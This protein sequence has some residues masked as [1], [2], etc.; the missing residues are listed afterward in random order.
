MR[1][2]PLTSSSATSFGR[3][4]IYRCGGRPIVGSPPTTVGKTFA[5]LLPGRL[6]L[7]EAPEGQRSARGAP[8]A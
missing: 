6:R 4:T 2:S 3:C 5:T 7:A 1:T 8:S